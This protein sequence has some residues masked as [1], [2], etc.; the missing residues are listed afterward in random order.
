MRTFFAALF[1]SILCAVPGLA[2]PLLTT[3]HDGVSDRFVGAS[4]APATLIVYSSPTC[5]YCIE[6]EEGILPQLNERYVETGKL[7]IAIR[8]FVRN[9]IDAV[10]FLVAEAT[11]PNR[12]DATVARFMSRFQEIAKA[13]DPEAVLRTIASEAGIDRAAFDAAVENTDYLARLNA[14]TSRASTEFGVRGTPTFFLNGKMLS[15]DGTISSFATE[16]DKLPN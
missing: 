11:E 14:M 15:Y 4:S 13:N 12:H 6:F 8:P 10:I 9:S 5:K 16:I 7:R 3:P 1:I 2:S